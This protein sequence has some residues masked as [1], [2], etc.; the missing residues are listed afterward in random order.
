MKC[1][2]PPEM[3]KQ[4]MSCFRGQ[5]GHTIVKGVIGYDFRYIFVLIRN[6]KKII[7]KFATFLN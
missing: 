6:K 7:L 1:P 2:P 4:G 3:F 5:A